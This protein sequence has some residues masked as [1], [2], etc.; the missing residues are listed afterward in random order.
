MGK[1]NSQPDRDTGLDGSPPRAYELSPELLK[2]FYAQEHR[3][4]VALRRYFVDTW[5]MKPDRPERVGARAGLISTL[6]VSLLFRGVVVGGGTATIAVLI[7]QNLL[8]QKQNAYFRDQI[9]FSE[10]RAQAAEDA[11]LLSQFQQ[12]LATLYDKEASAAERS[13]ALRVVLAE[14]PSG[15]SSLDLSNARLN[16]TR[17][18]HVDLS[19]VQMTGADMSHALWHN[20]IMPTRMNEADLSGAYFV[21]CDWSNTW[22]QRVKIGQMTRANRSWED[23]VYESA[24]L[25]LRAAGEYRFELFRMHSSDQWDNFEGGIQD[26]D[27]R[28]AER[29][30]E[31]DYNQVFKRQSNYESPERADTVVPIWWEQDSQASVHGFDEYV[32]HGRY[33]EQLVRSGRMPFGSGSE[34]WACI[35]GKRAEAPS[36]HNCEWR[37]FPT[38]DKGD[39]WTLIASSVPLG[40]RN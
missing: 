1:P 31:T 26:K 37:I 3:L 32:A 39:V 8:I 10:E 11:S 4:L 9:Q 13:I 14:R 2:E 23:E 16:G 15:V 19:E 34:Q 22:A 27:L 20:I 24:L 21:D 18:S 6:W 36:F 28:V 25:T 35:G 40:R 29:M 38:R 12:A 30:S 7:W 33:I 5:H 17:L